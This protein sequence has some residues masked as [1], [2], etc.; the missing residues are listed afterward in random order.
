MI[1]LHNPMK[2]NTISMHIIGG[3]LTGLLVLILAYILLFNYFHQTFTFPALGELHRRMPG[4]YLVDLVPAFIVIGSFFLGRR[5]ARIQNQLDHLKEQEAGHYK[6]IAGLIR[7]LSEG[8][9][10]KDFPLDDVDP[11]IVSSLIFLQQRL[12]DDKESAD[13]ARVEDEKQRWISGGLAA[14]GDLLRA[15]ADDEEKL[16]YAV[17]SELVKYMN[18]NQGG[19]FVTRQATGERH[20]EMI[21]CHAYDRK[22]FPGKKLN[23]GE[24]LI[25]AV[26]IEKQ[27]FYTDRIPENYLNITSGLGRATPRY[28][29]IVPIYI[30]EE[31]YGVLE[32]ASFHAFPEH[33]V[34]F[35]ERVAESTASTL[36]NMY[37]NLRTETLLR[38]TQEQAALLARHE[39][40][41]RKNL[42][43]LRA[44]QAEAARQSEQFISFTNTVNHTLIRAEYAPDGSLVYANT[45]FLRQL[46]YSGNREVEGKHIASFIHASDRA[47][48]SGM[49][50]K[51][52]QGGPHFEGYMRHVTKLGQ[53]LWTMATYTCLRKEDASIDKII[54]L[55]I[56]ATSQKEESLKYQ[57]KINAV[58]QLLPQ[59]ELSTDGRILFANDLFRETLFGSKDKDLIT[60]IFE[61]AP[62]Q[63]QERFNEMWEQIVRGEPFSG[64]VRLVAENEEERWFQV[65]MSPVK[66]PSGEV[67]RVFFLGIDNS[68]EK[69]LEH[70]LRDQNE[71]IVEAEQRI[72]MQALDMENREREILRQRSDDRKEMQRESA[73]FSDILE[74]SPFPVIAVNNQGFVVLFN[75]VA[76][77]YFKLQK[78]NVLNQPAVRI[79]GLDQA[80]TFIQAFY[81]PEKKVIEADQR[82]VVLVMP[83]KLERKVQVSVIET[84]S[85]K[86]RISTLFIHN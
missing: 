5:H 19:F 67:Y 72:N 75:H 44:T 79:F 60:S 71:Q 22:K 64:Q 81:L 85:G 21:A 63:E 37:N 8:K 34:G 15:N 57:G 49:W 39:E 65:N 30:E 28:L 3:I 59:A 83:D 82:E 26:A 47:W 68:R 24:G 20:L 61:L 17:V 78:N 2:R 42:D 16:G 38:E 35:V 32:L 73:R 77:E 53:E 69:E 54:F 13:A 33:H 31:V 45:R 36:Q 29:L 10:I 46:G 58:N 1:Y 12:S 80:D 70:L 41:A 40:Q 51:L 43:E 76:E 9:L 27:S 66:A 6:K 18:I 23:W 84:K 4:F 52:S 55:A 14:F 50:E 25:G 48:F 7:D 62:L 86:E 11:G 74:K 56:D